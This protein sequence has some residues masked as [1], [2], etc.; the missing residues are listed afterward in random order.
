[1]A[2]PSAEDAQHENG[3]FPPLRVNVFLFLATFLTVFLAGAIHRQSFDGKPFE[4]SAELWRAAIDPRFLASGWTFA[5]PLLAIL[6][7]HEFGHYFAALY[8]RVP[9]SLP[10]FIPLPL[11]SPF[12]TMGAV[13]A[14]PGRIRSR[15][16]LL[17]IG[18]AGPLAGLVVAIPVIAWGLLQSPVGPLPKEYTQEGQSLFYLAMKR[19]VLGPIPDGS[20]VSLSPTA[21][22]GWAGILVTMINLLPFGQL[23]GGHIAYALFGPIQNR[24]AVWFRRSLLVLFVYNLFVFLLPVL[25]KTSRLDVGEAVMNSSFWLVWY[26]FL[27]LLASLSGREHP[28]FEPG[29]LSPGRRA[30]AWL[31]LFVFVA[32]F[33]PTPWAVMR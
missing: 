15:N 24:L 7:A 29:P 32:L 2:E 23:D 16:A 28:P 10:Y 9:A 17:D 1:M 19:L 4:S 14:M 13:I 33:M 3:G 8:H 12:G 11:L 6:V 20:D 27:W 22:A 25:R 18:A 21:F 26:V 31:C 5:V 30:V